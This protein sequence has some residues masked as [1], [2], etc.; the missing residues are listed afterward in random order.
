MASSWVARPEAEIEQLNQEE[1]IEQ[2][3]D[4]GWTYKTPNP[5]EFKSPFADKTIIL[6]P[7]LGGK[8]DVTSTQ[9]ADRLI[10]IGVGMRNNIEE[11]HIKEFPCWYQDVNHKRCFQ[12]LLPGVEVTGMFYN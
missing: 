6:S 1:D 12:T 7:I 11:M 8:H 10:E 5:M 2:E 3:I 9:V 4:N